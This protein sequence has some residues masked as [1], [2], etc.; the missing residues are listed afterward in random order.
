MILILT[1]QFLNNMNMSQRAVILLLLTF[2][3]NN[4]EK[5][6]FQKMKHFCRL[7]AVAIVVL[8]TN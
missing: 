4:A 5:M 6:E 7:A 1:Q 3:A 8:K 2:H